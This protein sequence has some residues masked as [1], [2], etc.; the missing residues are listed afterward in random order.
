MHTYAQTR[1]FPATALFYAAAVLHTAACRL[2]A[3]ATRLDA[4]IAGAPAQPPAAVGPE[5]ISR[6][7]LDGLAG[8]DV[9]VLKDIGAPHWL[10]ARAAGEPDRERLR[11]I[12]LEHR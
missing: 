9:H 5:A 12:G 8:L 2:R 1:A 10:V 6:R 7:E 3:A 11:W 4:R